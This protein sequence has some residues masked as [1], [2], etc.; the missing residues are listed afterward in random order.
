MARELSRYDSCPLGK[1]LQPGC[2]ICLECE[3]NTDKEKRWVTHGGGGYHLTLCDKAS[4]DEQEYYH[5]LFHELWSV[6]V[7]TSNYNKEDWMKIE[8]QLLAAK[9]IKT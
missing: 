4:T 5:K 1:S 7:K 9:L 2:P 8:E 6:A 3:H